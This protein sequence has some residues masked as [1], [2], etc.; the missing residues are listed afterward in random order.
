MANSIGQ[1]NNSPALSFFFEPMKQDG[2]IKKIIAVATLVFLTII[3]AGI[4]LIPFLIHGTLSGRVT[5][6]VKTL[7][8]LVE[9]PST[10]DKRGLN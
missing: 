10:R 7:K 3:T 1:A 5:T 6:P 2:T 8:N 4:W 9:D